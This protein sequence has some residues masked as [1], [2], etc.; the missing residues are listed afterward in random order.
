MSTGAGLHVNTTI[1]LGRGRQ[2]LWPMRVT[3]PESLHSTTA[4]GKAVGNWEPTVLTGGEG[5][6]CR[7]PG[8]PKSRLSGRWADLLGLSRGRGSGSRVGSLQDDPQ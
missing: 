7:S 3:W 1:F 4:G 8:D 5:H 2:Q 6:T